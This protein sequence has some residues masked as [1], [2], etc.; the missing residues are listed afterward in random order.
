MKN[1]TTMTSSSRSLQDLRCEY[2]DYLLEWVDN[3]D[4]E[5]LTFEEFV[6]EAA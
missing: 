1:E 6:A 3:G 5:P 2:D 4:N